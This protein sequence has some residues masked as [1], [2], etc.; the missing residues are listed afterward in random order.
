MCW[1][2]LIC[3]AVGCTSIGRKAA[4]RRCVRSVVQ[5]YARC[6]GS[7]QRGA[8]TCSC[9]RA[10]LDRLVPADGSAHRPS[11]EACVRRAPAHAAACLRIQ[12]R[13]RWPRHPIA[14]ALPG[15][16]Q[17]AE[18]GALHR[19][20]ERESVAQ[21]GFD[22]LVHQVSP[23]PVSLADSASPPKAPRRAGR[24]DQI[25]GWGRGSTRE[26]RRSYQAGCLETWRQL[27]CSNAAGRA[28]SLG[29]LGPQ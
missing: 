11:R 9:D 24:A 17:L 23:P 25:N 3:I 8:P 26:A 22:A 16:S 4:R 27:F 6:V 20:S 7:Y 2:R 5:S 19:A 10:R 29:G 28:D 18:H 12:A 1:L 15:A 14:R 21:E 13:Q